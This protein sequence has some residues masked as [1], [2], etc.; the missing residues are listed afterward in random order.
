MDP[1]YLFVMPITAAAWIKLGVHPIVILIE[2][3]IKASSFLKIKST[4]QLL[5]EMNVFMLFFKS[6]K[7]SPTSLSQVRFF[8]KKED[9][10]LTTS[11][12]AFSYGCF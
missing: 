7:I 8:N 2:N 10:F 5:K 9:E 6:K 4:I 3:N 1:R 11:R 12:F